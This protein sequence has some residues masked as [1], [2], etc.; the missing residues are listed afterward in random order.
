MDP[1]KRAALE[2]LATLLTTIGS[3][4]DAQDHGSKDEAERMRRDASAGI[5]ALIAAHPF[6]VALLPGL[7]RSL[8]TRGIEG[9][10]WSALVDAVERE[11]R[12]ASKGR[13]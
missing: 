10:G 2:R 13:R 12:D 9:S 11:L 6:I 7:V 3:A 8:E 5:R 4:N 1:A